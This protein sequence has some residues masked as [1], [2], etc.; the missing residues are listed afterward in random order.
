MIFARHIQSRKFASSLSPSLMAAAASHVRLFFIYT[1]LIQ[2]QTNFDMN[3]CRE[4]YL[5]DGY[6]VF[7]NVIPKEI[8]LEIKEE[9]R[10]IVDNFQEEK[11]E[12]F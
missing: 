11:A 10:E 12:T 2:F 4:N 1:Y 7:H 5:R 9:I 8:V 6:V 3:A